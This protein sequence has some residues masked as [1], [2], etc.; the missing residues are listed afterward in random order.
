M[1]GLRR[2]ARDLHE[3]FRLHRHFWTFCRR[4]QEC[5]DFRCCRD[6]SDPDGEGHGGMSEVRLNDGSVRLEVDIRKDGWI[7]GT[8]WMMMEGGVL[9][10]E[11]DARPEG[12]Y[13]N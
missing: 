1:R 13:G 6:G 10:V 7:V 5:D 2:L 4:V 3:S 9:G 12:V 8:W 11:V